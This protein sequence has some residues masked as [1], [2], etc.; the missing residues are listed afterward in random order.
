MGLAFDRASLGNLAILVFDQ[1]RSLVQTG[2]KIFATLL[3]LTVAAILGALAFAWSGLGDIAASQGHWPFVEQFLDFGMRH[4]VTQHASGIEVPKL[5]DPNMI[6]L[7]AAHFHRGCAFCH[8]AHGIPVNPIAKHMLPPPP[9]LAVKMR[10]WQPNDLFWIVKNGL[11]YT[12]MPGWAAI[13]R[14]DEI[15]AVVAFLTR[16]QGLDAEAY[17]DLALGNVKLPQQNGVELA[18]VESNPRASGACARC[19]GDKGQLPLSNLVPILHGQPADYLLASLKAY[20]EGKRRSGIMQPL[21][22]DLREEDMRELAE[23]YSGLG[24]P[25][26]TEHADST[27]G[28]SVERGRKLAIEGL[29]NAGVPPCATCHNGAGSYPHLDGQHPAYMARQL[30]LRKAGLGPSTE[31]AGIMAPIAQRLSNE[32]I[33]AVSNYFGSQ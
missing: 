11:K 19:H 28:A 15:W 31:A 25:Q 30:R 29:P 2:V 26:M 20:A 10:P 6:R 8:G 27:D 23:Y 32:D 22:A 9:D 18:T 13:E 16:V 5:D 17:R 24:M 12:G 1:G 14:E 33:D 3:G 4:A 21:A 7:G